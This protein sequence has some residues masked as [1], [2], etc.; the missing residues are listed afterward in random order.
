MRQLGT[1][2]VSVSA[3][4]IGGRSLGAMYA[5]S[6]V[7]RIVHEG[8][9]AG[10][11][12]FGN[13]WEYQDGAAEE[14]LGRALLGRRDKAFIMTQV[15]THGRDRAVGL[16][17]LD[18]SL[19][20]LQTDHIDLWQIHECIYDDDPDL[21][22]AHGGV[23]EALDAAK[24]QGKV[25][26]VGFSGHKDPLIHLKMLAHDY[27]F[28]TVQM[29]LNPFDANFRS[30][31]NIV[32]PEVVNRGIAAIG[33]KSMNGGG[34]AIKAGLLSPDESLRYAMSLPVLTTLCGIDSYDVF[35]QDLMIAQSFKAMSEA[36]LS[37]LRTRVL[38]FS[39][40]GRYELYK[41]SMLYDEAVGRAT[42]KF[43]DATELP[44]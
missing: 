15:C 22:F 41:S 16:Q 9:D 12:F 6:E 37:A 19:R 42:H 31:Q 30:F 44:A 25:R 24:T 1:S 36:E 5:E 20:R 18:Q 34:E 11:N 4:G 27:K 43:P 3:I 17:Q 23:I 32:L 33:E 2:G 8:L 13:A 28:D 39:G 40:D 29:P 35:Q 26:F 10:I 21:H 38:P 14:R 7:Q